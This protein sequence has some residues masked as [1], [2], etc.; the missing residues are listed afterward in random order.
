MHKERS[1]FCNCVFT[2]ILLNF[3]LKRLENHKMLRY[4]YAVYIYLSFSRILRWG[5]IYV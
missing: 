4:N 1:C 2:Y 3:V 5:D